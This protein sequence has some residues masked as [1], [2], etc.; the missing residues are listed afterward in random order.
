[1]GVLVGWFNVFVL[2]HILIPNST[3]VLGQHRAAGCVINQP[4][5]EFANDLV[6][7]LVIG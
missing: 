7:K 6:K 3:V 5:S 4:V 1:M 2:N